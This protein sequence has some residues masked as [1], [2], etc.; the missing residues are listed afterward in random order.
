MKRKLTQIIDIPGLLFFSWY[1]LSLTKEKGTMGHKITGVSTLSS[2]LTQ[3]PFG[4]FTLDVSS[5]S[6]ND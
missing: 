6:H 4:Q 5:L 2:S 3:K 1:T